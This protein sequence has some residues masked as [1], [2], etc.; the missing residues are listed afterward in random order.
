[1]TTQARLWG[2]RAGVVVLTTSW[3]RRPADGAMPADILGRVS[4]PREPDAAGAL[5]VGSG[6]GPPLEAIGLSN[7]SGARA[8]LVRDGER[9]RLLLSAERVAG[10]HDRLVISP[11]DAG[12]EVR[13]DSEALAEWI[14]RAPIT[15]RGVARVPAWASVA[16]FALVI[17]IVVLVVVGAV[18][19]AAWLGDVVAGR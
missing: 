8:I 16:G 3:Y 19:V 6:E 10:N 15:A 9:P 17:G 13:R 12:H 14:A 7:G 18:T 4:A 2:S 1:M 11:L 5:A